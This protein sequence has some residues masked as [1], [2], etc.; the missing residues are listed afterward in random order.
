MSLRYI[1]VGLRNLGIRACQRC[2]IE[3]SRQFSRAAVDV[4]S[5]FRCPFHLLSPG[6]LCCHLQ[7]FS[8]SRSPSSP[9]LFYPYSEACTGLALLSGRLNNLSCKAVDKFIRQAISGL[10]LSLSWPSESGDVWTHQIGFI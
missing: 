8:D 2:Q 1:V 9:F 5:L 7:V 4:L 3:V 6:K 10:L